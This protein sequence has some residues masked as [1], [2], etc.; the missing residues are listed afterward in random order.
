MVEEKQKKKTARWIRNGKKGLCKEEEQTLSLSA[1][2]GDIIILKLATNSST[3]G[4]V[5]D[6]EKPQGHGSM[7][8][9]ERKAR[10]AKKK[11]EKKFLYHI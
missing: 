8:G 3:L 2:Y 11:K 4:D 6:K 9:K 10:L 5:S 7:K 1:V